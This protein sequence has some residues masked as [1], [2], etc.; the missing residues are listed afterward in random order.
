MSPRENL[1]FC[2]YNLSTTYTNLDTQ[3]KTNFMP[4]WAETTSGLVYQRILMPTPSTIMI[5]AEIR[6]ID[7][8]T[9]VY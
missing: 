7:F 4:S 9:K 5:T 1:D 3:E 8:I 6:L 2:S